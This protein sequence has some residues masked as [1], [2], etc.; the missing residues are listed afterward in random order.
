MLI[1]I[2][3]TT[4]TMWMPPGRVIRAINSVDRSRV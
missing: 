3:E 1:F 4:Y 2:N